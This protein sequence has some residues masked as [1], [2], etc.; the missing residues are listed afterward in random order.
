[1]LRDRAAYRVAPLL[2]VLAVPVGA[3]AQSTGRAPANSTSSSASWGEGVAI[4]AV[5]LVLLIGI[6][7]AVKLYD[8]KRRRVEETAALQAFVSEALMLDRTVTGLPIA[9]FVS[10]SLWPRSPVV[11]SVRGSVPTPELRNVVMRLVEGEAFR[12]QPGALVEDRLMVD[13]M[14]GKHVA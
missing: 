12:R 13:P 5:V 6:G 11:I 1:M 14:I 3:S 9:A 7:V 8:V 2:S 10:R 4:L